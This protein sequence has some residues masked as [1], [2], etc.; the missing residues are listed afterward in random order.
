MLSWIFHAMPQ[1]LQVSLSG[2]GEYKLFSAF[3]H[4]LGLPFFGAVLLTQ[5]WFS[6]RLRTCWLPPA[7]WNLL[8]HTGTFCTLLLFLSAWTWQLALHGAALAFQLCLLTEEAAGLH[9]VP[10]PTRQ[11]GGPL[12]AGSCAPCRA[13][14]S[15]FLSLRSAVLPWLIGHVWEAVP[16][17]ISDPQWLSGEEPA[18]Q[19]RRHKRRGFNPWVRKIP[20]RRAQPPTPV[21]LSGETYGQ[22]ILAGYSPW[23]HTRVRQDWRDLAYT[24]LV[25]SILFS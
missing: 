8:F 11:P 10:L 25:L 2:W 24:H 4:L 20:W 3:C 13:R 6:H 14:H 15:C 22:R 18:C 23:D 5:M 1:K 21:L 9:S 17:Y 16:S 7:T 19:Y 12:Q